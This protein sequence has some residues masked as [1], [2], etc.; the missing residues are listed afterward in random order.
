MVDLGVVEMLV[1][2]DGPAVINK[3]LIPDKGISIAIGLILYLNK[4]QLIQ[5]L[6]MH[7]SQ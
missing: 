7:L 5:N 3:E 6:D 1:T 4:F 2:S